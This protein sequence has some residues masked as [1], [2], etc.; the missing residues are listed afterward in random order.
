LGLSSGDQVARK[1]GMIGGF[2]DS[3]RSRLKFVKIIRDNKT[4]IEKKTAHLENVGKKLKDILLWFIDFVS[5]V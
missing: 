2:Y 1:G 4:E 5:L 3:R